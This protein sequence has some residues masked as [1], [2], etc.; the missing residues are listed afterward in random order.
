MALVL[1]S[2]LSVLLRTQLCLATSWSD[3]LSLARPDWTVLKDC[4][5][6]VEC[7]GKAL[8]L[9][10]PPKAPYLYSAEGIVSTG[11]NA[12]KFSCRD[13]SSRRMVFRR[14]HGP[15]FLQCREDQ[16]LHLGART[17][18]GVNYVQM[19]VCL[20]TPHGLGP[21]IASG[22]TQCMNVVAPAKGK[23]LSGWVTTREG[24]SDNG[25]LVGS[26][27]MSIS[28]IASRVVKR[29][30]GV[31][32]VHLDPQDMEPGSIY[33]VCVKTKATRYGGS[34]ELHAESL[35]D[36]ETIYKNQNP[37]RPPM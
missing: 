18:D 28:V 19:G 8:G 33:R 25:S 1:M 4:E 21:A 20:Y 26:D 14:L 29:E 34:L 6:A 11:D 2:V 24:L 30:I 22:Q 3:G 5:N 35:P 23:I 32:G 37:I 17:I 15:Y 16:Y 12:A 13:L 31:S 9:A 27:F 36:I 10:Y 7:C